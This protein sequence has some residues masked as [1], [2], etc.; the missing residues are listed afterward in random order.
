MYNGFWLELVE[1]RA[2]IEADERTAWVL[3]EKDL[4]AFVEFL[5]PCRSAGGVL[6]PGECWGYHGCEHCGYCGSGNPPQGCAACDG[7]DFATGFQE[8]DELS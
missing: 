5:S 8:G 7:A 3:V 4:D 1:G 6:E 2:H